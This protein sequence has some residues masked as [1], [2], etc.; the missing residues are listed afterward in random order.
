MNTFTK[1]LAKIV[2]V[3]SVAY[4][5]VSTHN[6]YEQKNVEL[7]ESTVKSLAATKSLEMNYPENMSVAHFLMQSYCLND[8][9]S[10]KS[11]AAI[12]DFR[13]R[14]KG[15]PG[16]IQNPLDADKVTVPMLSIAKYNT[17]QG[18]CGQRDEK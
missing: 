15:T 2:L 10:I 1:G 17:S 11:R 6:H 7:F 8:L 14:N 9:S 5:A 3:G 16:M 13:M 12:Y 4:G 18:L